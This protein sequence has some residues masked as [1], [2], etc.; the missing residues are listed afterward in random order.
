MCPRTMHLL[1]GGALP[2]AR[3]KKLRIK[4]QPPIDKWGHPSGGRPKWIAALLVILGLALA[5]V[6][7]ARHHDVFGDGQ[8]VLSEGQ[9]MQAVTVGGPRR[10]PPPK[11]ELDLAIEQFL[12]DQAGSLAEQGSQDASKTGDTTPN[13]FCPT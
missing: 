9:L 1:F 6:A 13:D 11:S 7:T 5:G 10:P 3:K 4:P 12:G 8:V 2:V